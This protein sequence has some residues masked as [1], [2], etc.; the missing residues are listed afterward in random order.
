ML[1]PS[2]ADGVRSLV[3]SLGCNSR[4]SSC[5]VPMPAS[6][7]G[8]PAA[9]GR[10]SPWPAL[11]AVVGVG[12]SSADGRIGGERRAGGRSGKGWGGAAHR[13]PEWKGMRRAACMEVG[14]G[15]GGD[16][17]NKA[18]EKRKINY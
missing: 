5:A 12:R 10:S 11:Q 2:M 8:G 18:K 3:P 15:G 1:A 4:A 6:S 16:L 9:L 13:P 14:V 7:H 17:G